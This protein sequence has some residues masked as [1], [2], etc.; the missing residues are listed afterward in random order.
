MT[1]SNDLK[2]GMILEIDKT[3]YT[4]VE[5]QHFKPGKGGAFVRTKLK[6]LLSGNV[7]EKTF[8]SGEKVNEQR[9]ERRDLEYSYHDGSHYVFLDPQTFEQT[10]IG[11]ELLGNT[12]NYM[13][14]GIAITALF[15]EGRILTI[16]PP[17]FVILKVT[18]T[19]P[20]VRGNTVTG[21]TK[22]ATLETGLVI[23]VPLFIDENDNVKVDTRTNSYVERV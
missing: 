14:E 4:V 15:F 13:K 1:L 20:G 10:E 5:F 12:V 7:V 18:S 17:T 22:T 11:E 3:L 23:N 2:N 9:I 8:R 16:E 21:A 19:P 6:N